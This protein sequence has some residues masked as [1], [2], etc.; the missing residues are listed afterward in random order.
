MDGS[1]YVIR[2]DRDVGDGIPTKYI[3]WNNP[4]IQRMI[5]CVDNFLILTKDGKLW[6]NG[7][8][9]DPKVHYNTLCVTDNKFYELDISSQQAE[10]KSGIEI[11]NVVCAYEGMFLLLGTVP[12][13]E[14]DLMKI[15][16][17]EVFVDVIIRWK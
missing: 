5:A 14:L 17:R 10:C 16:K 11:E 7:V 12:R 13:N 4:N 2:S 6:A 1:I 8:E 15:W 9:R 3:E